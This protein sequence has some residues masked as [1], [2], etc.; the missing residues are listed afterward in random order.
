MATSGS[1]NYSAN[2]DDLISEALQICKVLGEGG[3][4]TSGQL[5]DSSRTLNMMVKAWQNKGANL[6]AIATL[7]LFPVKNQTEYSFGTGADRM[8]LSTELIETELNGAHAS[9][10]TSL[11]VA[12][13]DGTTGMAASDVI[14]VQTD[15]GGISW[16]TISGSPTSTTITLAAGISAAAADNNN[17]YTYTT[18]FSNRVLKVLNAWRR[19]DSGVDVPISIVSRQTYSDLPDKDETGPVNTVYYDPQLDPG[20]LSLWPTPS[21]N[22]TDELIYLRAQRPIEDFD[23]AANTPDYPQEWYLA[24]AWNLAFLLGPKFGLSGQELQDIGVIAATH[25]KDALDFDT[26]DQS[27]YIMPDEM[28]GTYRR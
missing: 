18:V 6:W 8:C 10:V 24:L 14:G 15:S 16:T 26:E 13:K 22:E 1:V 3:S 20:K 5:S 9:G 25:F 2:R 11:T 27:I 17:V 21:D 4:P 7:V 19:T 23:A 28:F 12:G